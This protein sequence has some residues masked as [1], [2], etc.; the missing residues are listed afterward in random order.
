MGSQLLLNPQAQCVIYGNTGMGSLSLPQITNLFRNLTHQVDVLKEGLE[1]PEVFVDHFWDVGV[2]VI[3][4]FTI[5]IFL[6]IVW[7]FQ[8]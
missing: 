4:T 8:N 7:G 1:E 5:R 3:T 2:G 6:A